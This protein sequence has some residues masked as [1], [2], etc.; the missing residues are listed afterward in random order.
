MSRLPQFAE[1]PSLLGVQLDPIDNDR[2]FKNRH[3][4][5][6][7]NGR[8]SLFVKVI[9]EARFYQAE[10]A[11]GLALDQTKIS[12]T[13][14]VDHGELDDQRHWVA[15][16]WREFSEFTPTLPHIEAA[17]QIL[18]QLHHHTQ[19]ASIPHVPIYES[20]ASLAEK[21]IRVVSG[22]DAALATRLTAL[23]ERLVVSWGPGDA[24]PDARSLLHGDFGWRNM[25]ISSGGAIAFDFER[26]ALGPT[27]LD[28]AK[29]WDRELL[30]PEHRAAFIR[31]YQQHYSDSSWLSEINLV[32][33]KAVAAIVAYARSRGDREFRD[34]AFVILNRL[35][36]E[37][38]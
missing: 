7:Q 27:S 10:V 9:K 30:D 22:F 17:G 29:L 13:R 28:F 23:H 16:V 14:I 24:P 6:T 26:A 35:E 3:F 34:H 18:G 21:K 25:G 8:P 1:L 20:V 32:R 15:Y 37:L 4:R 11:A 31:G 38:S 2:R 33:L 12:A 36:E 5:A 19:G